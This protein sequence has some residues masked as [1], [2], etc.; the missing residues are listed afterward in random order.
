MPT[1]AGRSLYFRLLQYVKPYR[2]RFAGGLLALAVVAACEPAMPALMKPMLDGT[3]VDKDPL[4]MTWIPALIVGLFL[5]RGVAG[6][7]SDYAVA[8]IGTRVVMDLRV[9]MFERL[10]TLPTPFFDAS[11]SGKLLSK[12][13][14]DVANVMTAAT[15]ALTTLVKES[16]VVAGL[17]GWLL[18]LS[19][20]L[21]LVVLVVSPVV[22]F[23]VRKIARR[24]RGASRGAQAAMGGMVHVLDE[25]IG[26]HRVIKVYGGQA[27]EAGRFRVA[28]GE[29]RHF[30]LRQAATTAAGMPVVQL[31]TAC[32]VAVVIWIATGQAKS[33]ELSVGSFVSYMVAMLMVMPPLRKL[34]SVTDSLQRGLAAAESVFELIDQSP[35]ADPGRAPIGRARG[36][37]TLEGVTFAYAADGREAL[38]GVDLHIAPG[39]M[40][41]L[42]GASGSGKTTLANLLPRFYRAD[43]GSLRIDGIDV[44]HLPLADLRRQIAL[45]SQ[46]VVL[47]NDTVA[48]NIAYGG[49][50]DATRAEIEAAAEAA[51]AAGFIRQMAQGFDTL[52]GENGVRLSGGQ[53]QRLAIARA[54]LKDAPILILDE[55]T[56]A[57]DSESEKQVQA[58]LERLMHGRT[59]LVIAHRLSTI[60]KADRIVVME[61]GHVVESGKHDELMRRAGVYARLHALQFRENGLEDP[62]GEN[63]AHRD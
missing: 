45:V 47:F 12:V 15:N 3:F 25:A 20:K 39:E 49:R 9:A 10:L 8:W 42:V 59:T 27:Y 29:V 58:A 6:Y 13:S 55:A 38:S 41:A 61:S 4:L 34:T 36:E 52:I 24:L 35:E 23:L 48:A 26:G 54:I 33:G 60:E 11:V 44:A 21:T 2:G 50:R 14:F 63:T 19:W 51:Y 43:S 7:I 31:V 22:A 16:L 53:R 17:V 46:D 30:L 28:A 62:T 18:W 57:L 40:V 1:Q 32:A 56:S 5:V 37:V